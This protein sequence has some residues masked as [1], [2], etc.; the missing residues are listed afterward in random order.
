MT[1]KYCYTN[2]WVVARKK[3]DSDGN[4]IKAFYY[5]SVSFA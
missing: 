4:E 3:K 2:D 1:E 5:V